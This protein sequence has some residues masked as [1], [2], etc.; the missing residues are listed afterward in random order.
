MLGGGRSAIYSVKNERDS[1][2][3][4]A[5]IYSVQKAPSP[6]VMIDGE[7][8]PQ[9]GQD[10]STYCRSPSAT[11]AK[12]A[13]NSRPIIHAEHVNNKLAAVLVLVKLMACI[14]G[15]VPMALIMTAAEQRR[16]PP[17]CTWD[18]FHLSEEMIGL[19]ILT[20]PF[21]YLCILRGLR[22]EFFALLGGA[23]RLSA[24]IR[25][26][27]RVGS[28]INY[29]QIHVLETNDCW[30]PG[31][32]E[33]QCRNNW[34]FYAGSCFLFGNLLHENVQSHS[35]AQRSQQIDVMLESLS[36]SWKKPP[37]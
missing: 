16:Y 37:W 20:E 30:C 35:M 3:F 13:A 9:P 5:V 32:K 29:W 10:P 25:P 2:S 26:S 8:M 17:A 24:G 11:V 23:N 1:F 19:I 33:F 6:K 36:S 27:N 31:T 28:I 12:M 7:G 22:E 15:G 4:P 14:Y 34:D 21:V 18:A